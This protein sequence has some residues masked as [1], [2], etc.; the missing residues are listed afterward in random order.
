MRL[1]FLILAMLAWFS[2]F[3]QMSD[4]DFRRMVRAGEDYLNGLQKEVRDQEGRQLSRAL[5]DDVWT[6]YENEVARAKEMVDRGADIVIEP[7]YYVDV[8]PILQVIG[9]GDWGKE[10][11]QIEQN[12]LDIKNKAASGRIVN[13]TTFDTGRPD[14]VDIQDYVDNSWGKNWTSSG[15]E[16]DR[17]SHSTHCMGIV[18][19]A[20]DDVRS[21]IADA[22]K[23][24]NGWQKVLSDGGS[25]QYSW[26]AD[27]VKYQN[28]QSRERIARGEFCVYVLSLGGGSGDY[29]YEP[30]EEAFREAVNMGVLIITSA[31]NTGSYMTYPATS[32][33]TLGIGSLQKSGS[34]VVRSSFSSYGAL[35]WATAPGSSIYSTVL[36]DEYAHK[37][38]TSMSAPM[39]VQCVSIVACLNPTASASDIVRHMERYMSDLP[40]TGRDD[41]YGEGWPVMDKIYTIPVDSDPKPIEDCANGVD[42]DGDGLV[43][44]DDPDCDDYPACNPPVEEICDNGIDDDG[45]GLVDCD[46][47]DCQD[48]K[49]CEPDEVWPK[50]MYV[51]EL[52]LDK[53]DTYRVRWREASGPNQYL[54]FRI[55]IEAESETN[56]SDFA[57]DMTATIDRHFRGRGYG[58][59]APSDYYKAAYYVAY[60]LDL[61]EGKN[62]KKFRVLEVLAI[63]EEGYSVILEEQDLKNLYGIRSWFTNNKEIKELNAQFFNQN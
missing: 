28:Q 16:L 2:S 32:P 26:V 41:E 36:D 53:D 56:M 47:P 24:R 54:E 62:Y 30:L 6:T 57:K 12:Y 14:H 23:L 46:D 8:R 39:M 58:L 60:F 42:D 10:Y 38:G 40:P 50:R 55:K 49:G 61:I 29:K 3:A 59:N 25:G 34:T 31:G 48:F 35:L 51:S 33:Y 22:G 15:D 19:G 11:L 44:C 63:D 45:D 5:F 20:D 4:K 21:P 1:K 27:A 17:H 18:G 52:P 7:L 13:V 37:S 43:D 9:K